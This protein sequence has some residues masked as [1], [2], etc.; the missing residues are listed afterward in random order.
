M[1]KTIQFP[2]D[3]TLKATGEK[4][5]ALRRERV[6]G[7]ACIVVK[8]TDGAERAYAANTVRVSRG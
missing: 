8:D 7:V 4:V 1:P 5:T 6:G 3:A 2:A